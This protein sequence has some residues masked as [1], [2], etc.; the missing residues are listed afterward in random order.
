MVKITISLKLPPKLAICPG[1]IELDLT[2]ANLEIISRKMMFSIGMMHN[3]LR[4][5]TSSKA[6]ARVGNW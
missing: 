3:I 5:D 1:H 6:K 2:T 4:Q